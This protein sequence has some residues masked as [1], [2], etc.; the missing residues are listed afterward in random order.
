MIL[1]PSQ[2]SLL[3]MFASLGNGPNLYLIYS[4]QRQSRKLEA[5]AKAAILLTM[6]ATHGPD[7]PILPPVCLS[8]PTIV[9][10]YTMSRP[11]FFVSLMESCFFLS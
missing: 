3:P 5:N 10:L 2:F 6:L 8:N 7:L 1:F 9:L 4:R 11:W